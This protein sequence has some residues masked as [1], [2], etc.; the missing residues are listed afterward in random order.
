MIKEYLEEVRRNILLNITHYA[1]SDDTSMRSETSEDAQEDTQPCGEDAPENF[2]INLKGKEFLHIGMVQITFKPMTL[3]GLLE[4]FL[5]ALRDARNLNFRQSLMGSIESTVAYGPVYFNTQPNL[6]LSLTDSNILDTLTMNVKT[7]GY[8]YAPGSELICLSYRIYFKLLATL[9][10]R[11]K[12]Y[13][14]SD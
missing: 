12:L 5:T 7:H 6:Q 13:D 9:N 3:K 4:T 2:L 8:N 14:T 11:C 1:K 10:P